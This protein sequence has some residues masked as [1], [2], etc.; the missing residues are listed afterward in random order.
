MVYRKGRWG[1]IIDNDKTKTAL[2]IDNTVSVDDINKIAFENIDDI[3][4]V[5]WANGAYK[6]VKRVVKDVCRREFI[7][8]KTMFIVYDFADNVIMEDTT[9]ILRAIGTSMFAGYDI[10]VKTGRT[11]EKATS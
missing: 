4:I 7:L 2:I 6:S 3:L 8:C 10:H 9:D 5:V 11:E 1:F